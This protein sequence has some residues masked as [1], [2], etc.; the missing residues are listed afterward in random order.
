MKLVFVTEARF[1]KDAKG[2]FYCES[3]FNFELW[4]RYLTAFS[5]VIVMARTQFVANYIGSE[6][7]ISS[8]PRVS[9]IEIPYFIGPLQYLKK[10]KKI[11]AKIKES[12]ENINAVFICR[13]PG[14]IGNLAINYLNLKKKY[15][16]VEIV[17][18]P[19]DVFSPGSV[20]H[21]LRFYFRWKG[22]FNLKRNVAKASAALYV[23]ENAL[24]KRYPVSLNVYQT[25]AS[26]VKIKDVL[27]KAKEH[28]LKEQYTL[29]SVGSLEQMYKSP[30][31]V[32]RAIKTLNDEGIS[33]KLIWLGD[34]IY[35]IQMQKLA[36]ELGISEYVNFRGN[37]SVNEVRKHLLAS[38]IFILA[39]STEGLPRAV[40]EAMAVGLPCIGTKVGGIPELLEKE[41]LIPKNNARA[42]VEKIKNLIVEPTFYNQQAS[43]NLLNAQKYT[44]S[45]LTEKRAAFYNYLINLFS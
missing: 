2:N 43:R 34:G 35:K 21:W 14:T 42:L 7:H 8:G 31:I 28:I 11:N 22:Y 40:I 36:K 38:D 19:W 41:V 25:A 5:Q 10:R 12:V 16:G 3:S 18:D 37:V 32:L 27:I 39:S 26:N 45:V 33:C 23:T 29:I 13:I 44:E 24:Q 17:G 30:D 9:F 1:I 6:N 4:E 15:F 20:K